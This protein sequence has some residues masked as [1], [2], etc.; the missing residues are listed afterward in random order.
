MIEYLQVDEFCIAVKIFKN[1]L[2]ESRCAYCISSNNVLT[3]YYSMNI[4]G[5]VSSC[6]SLRITDFN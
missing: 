4:T 1:T 2:M 5:N 6:Y 3:F